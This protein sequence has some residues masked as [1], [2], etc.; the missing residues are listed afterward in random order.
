M[1]FCW[2]LYKMSRICAKEFLQ[3]NW[4]NIHDRYL[5]FIVS[6]F[7]RFYNN[8]CSDYFNEVFYLVD[9]NGVATRSCNK[10]LKLSF[11][12]LKLEM[13]SLSYVGPSTWNKTLPPP[14]QKKPLRLLPTSIALSKA[15]KWHWSIYL[16]LRLKR[17]HLEIA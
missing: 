6:D 8:Q 14:L 9:D 3:L 4:L 16:E 12:K 5:K 1:R 7:F 10:K 13:Q 15:I 11:C 17:K 2:Q